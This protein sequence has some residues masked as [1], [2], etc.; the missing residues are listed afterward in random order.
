MKKSIVIL[1]LTLAITAISCKKDE[2]IPDEIKARDFLY[3]LMNDLYYWNE[4][5]PVVNPKDYSDPYSLMAA[6][7]YTPLDRWS[8]VQDYDSFVAYYAGDFVGHGIRI[9]VDDDDQARIVMIYNNS[10]LYSIGVRRGWII[11][12]VNGTDIGALLA[13]GNYEAYTAVMQPAKAGI[14]NEFVFT[15]PETSTQLTV[16]ST[17]AEFDVNS[18]LTYK[19]LNLTSGITGYMAFESFL[20]NSAI[21]L[22]E[23]FTFFKANNIKDLILDLRYKNSQAILP[24]TPIPERYL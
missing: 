24:E 14:V 15:N 3:N 19:T 9:G 13:A 17:K 21:E 20:D 8:N 10:P 7:M 4:V 23:A 6:M 18:V 12:T 22:E 5:M 2:P 1:F 16:S 11:N